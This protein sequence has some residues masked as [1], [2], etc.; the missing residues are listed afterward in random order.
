MSHPGGAREVASR[1][2]EIKVS[3]PISVSAFIGLIETPKARKLTHAEPAR[4]PRL[5]SQ[6]QFLSQ[7]SSP[8]LATPR[9]CVEK[10]RRKALLKDLTGVSRS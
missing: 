9:P 3:H 4:H 5:A 6:E 2:A 1:I 8:C 7:L 10:I